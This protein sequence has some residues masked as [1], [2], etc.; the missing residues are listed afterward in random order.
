MELPV[1]SLIISVCGLTAACCMWMAFHPPSA[2][3]GR[4]KGDAVPSATD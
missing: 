3:T 1:A 4:R 2:L